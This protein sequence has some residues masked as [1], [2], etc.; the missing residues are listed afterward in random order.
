MKTFLQ[1]S[2]C[3]FVISMMGIYWMTEAVPMAVTALMPVIAFPLL[4]VTTTDDI[5]LLYMKET[6]MMF[7]GG[8]IIAIAVEHCNLHKRIALFIILR[9]G[10]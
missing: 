7:I 5:C 8:L 1:E 10:K 2:R 9:M 3:G 6:N 4:G